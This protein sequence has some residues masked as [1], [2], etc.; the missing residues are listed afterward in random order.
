[1]FHSQDIFTGQEFAVKLELCNSPKSYLEHKYGVLNT[2]QGGMTPGFP[3][4]VWLGREGVYR[5]MVLESLGP[6]LHKLSLQSSNSFSLSRVA[7]IRLQLVSLNLKG[8]LVCG[9]TH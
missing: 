6:S 5:V 7:K 2:L 9:L 4:P 3:Q 8:S 1:M